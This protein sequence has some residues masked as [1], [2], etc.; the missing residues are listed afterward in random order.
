M[1][2][3]RPSYCVARCGASSQRYKAVLRGLLARAL[4]DDQLNATERCETNSQPSPTSARLRSA[5]TKK[6]G[7]TFRFLMLARAWNLR[8]FRL[9]TVTS[10]HRVMFCG[11]GG[12]EQL[13]AAR[14]SVA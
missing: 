9:R 4:P 8:R 13:A 1:A 12:K 14:T 5:S 10:N 2:L 11:E 7:S 3:I 6:I